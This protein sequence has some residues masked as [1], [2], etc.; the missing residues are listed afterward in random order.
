M[1][2]DYF[3]KFTIITINYN[4]RDG[5]ER[6]IESVISQNFSDYEYL[7]ID[8]GSN[9]GSVDI[10]KK[11]SN[12]ISYWVSEP[13]NGIYNAM[14]KGIQKARGE[15]LNFMN[16]GD[17][18]YNFDTLKS[19]VKIGMN[20]DIVLGDTYE[21]KYKKIYPLR[22]NDPQELS[23]LDLYFY[24][25]NHQAAF[26]KKS[27]FSNTYY[28]ENLK[29]C[30]DWYFFVSKLV[31]EN[32][33]IQIV[34]NPVVIYDMGGISTNSSTECIKEKKEILGRLLPQRIYL[35]YMKFDNWYK[36][37]LLDVMITTKDDY[38]FQLFCSW[39]LKKIYFLYSLFISLFWSSGKR[40]SGRR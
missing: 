29:I 36:S 27:L 38:R 4:N 3:C 21:N 35:D 34:N 16:S 23:L 19:I 30:G 8:G 5:L 40:S 12:Q 18:F 2:E 33:S 37:P 15:Y 17:V 7:I 13:D 22:S 24:G 10:I 1:V 20:S 26:I 28:D 6:T 11:F 9:D 31:F 14:N 25:I 32:G 39:M